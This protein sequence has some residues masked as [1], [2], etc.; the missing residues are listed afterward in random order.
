LVRVGT[1]MAEHCDAAGNSPDKTCPQ[2]GIVSIEHSARQNTVSQCAG[3]HPAN[4]WNDVGGERSHFIAFH[5]FH[6]RNNSAASRALVFS[7]IRARFFGSQYSRQSLAAFTHRVFS[8]TKLNKAPAVWAGQR[9]MR[10]CDF[11]VVER[12]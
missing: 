7:L 12:D 11:P 4:R 3:D 9:I 6:I 2:D 10:H 5:A 8:Y 1:V